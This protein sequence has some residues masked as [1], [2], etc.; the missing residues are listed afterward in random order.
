[1]AVI[2]YI[3]VCFPLIRSAIVFGRRWSGMSKIRFDVNA[4][5]TVSPGI[6]CHLLDGAGQ[7]F[8]AV[9]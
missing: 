6:R 9:D 1:M 5:G 2:R 8:V 4:R 3:D 7:N